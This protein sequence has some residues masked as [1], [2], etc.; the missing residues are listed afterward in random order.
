[1]LA[2]L[3]FF[4]AF[5]ARHCRMKPI[6]L[7]RLTHR[8]QQEAVSTSETSADFFQ[9]TRRNNTEDG[10]LNISLIDICMKGIGT[11]SGAAL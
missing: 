4:F 1:M 2:V 3:I 10:H 7:E 9:T 6:A 11:W 5:Y 8:K